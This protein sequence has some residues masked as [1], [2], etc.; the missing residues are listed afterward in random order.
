MKTVTT[1]A[2]DSSILATFQRS[3]VEAD[4][5]CANLLS[6]FKSQKI[7]EIWVDID[8]DDEQ[9]GVRFLCVKEE[10]DRQRLD[11]DFG[12]W[13]DT[14]SLK[15]LNAPSWAQFAATF[16]K[17]CPNEAGV[18]FASFP[19]P[20]SAVLFFRSVGAIRHAVTGSKTAKQLT[21]ES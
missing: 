3:L 2:A 6:R 4:A 21:V 10:D 15:K 11:D 1:V 17:L 19:N 9:E 13:E 7:F 5:Y 20:Q 8:D 14:A 18:F 16:K 12:E